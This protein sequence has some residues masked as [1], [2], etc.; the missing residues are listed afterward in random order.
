NF[1]VLPERILDELSD[2]VNG[3]SPPMDVSSLVMDVTPAPQ[4]VAIPPSSS[5]SMPRRSSRASHP[6]L[7]LTNCHC[8]MVVQIIPSMA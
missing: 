5:P 4:L 2:G 7:Y 8:K 1:L 6:P 3:T